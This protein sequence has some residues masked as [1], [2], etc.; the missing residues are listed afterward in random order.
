[1]KKLKFQNSLEEYTISKSRS[2][3]TNQNN[4]TFSVMVMEGHVLECLRPYPASSL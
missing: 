2:S 1:M 4:T 3:I